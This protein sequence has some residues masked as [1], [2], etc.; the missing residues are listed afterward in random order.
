MKSLYISNVRI[1]TGYCISYGELRQAVSHCDLPTLRRWR[2]PD[3]TRQDLQLCLWKSYT[4]YSRSS[5]K[6]LFLVHGGISGTQTFLFVLKPSLLFPRPA[7]G[8]GPLFSHFFGKTLKFVVFPRR[9]WRMGYPCLHRILPIGT[10]LWQNSL[11]ALSKSSLFM[12]R[13][14]PDP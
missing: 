8:S 13:D 4:A 1:S 3:Q 6:F 14:T 7:D 10:E 9:I 11:L 5:P 12:N 2:I